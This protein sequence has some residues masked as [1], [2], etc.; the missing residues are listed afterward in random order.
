MFSKDCTGQ[1]RNNTGHQE[2]RDLLVGSN[3]RSYDSSKNATDRVQDSLFQRKFLNCMVNN[4]PKCGAL[5]DTSGAIRL[6]L[7]RLTDEASSPGAASNQIATFTVSDVLEREAMV[8]VV[9]DRNETKDNAGNEEAHRSC[10]AEEVKD[11]DEL[12]LANLHEEIFFVASEGSGDDLVPPPENTDIGGHPFQSRLL[13]PMS[14]NGVRERTNGGR[15]LKNNTDHVKSAKFTA[16]SLQVI[17]R[18]EAL[19][20]SAV[21]FIPRETQTPLTPDQHV[22]FVRGVQAFVAAGGDPYETA[23]LCEY[24][25]VRSMQDVPYEMIA[26]H[27]ELAKGAVPQRPD[28]KKTDASVQEISSFMHGVAAFGMPGAKGKPGLIYKHFF[29]NESSRK[30]DFPT[31]H[32][33]A[34]GRH[35]HYAPII[36]LWPGKVTQWK[37]FKVE[38]HSLIFPYTIPGFISKKKK[39]SD[40]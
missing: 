30:A 29:T 19:N 17:Y 3:S 15:A 8:L 32:A 11:H 40:S 25:A 28:S 5:S 13:V 20:I 24:L 36:S 34:A 23:D 6:S 4:S 9:K 39:K 31:T 16:F 10:S 14:V 22:A 21:R 33:R 12:L 1:I 18:D 26:V 2:G 27:L 37:E 35:A 7:Q 38:T